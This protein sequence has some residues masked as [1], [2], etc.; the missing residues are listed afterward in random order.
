MF[1]VHKKYCT[2]LPP[3]RL[4]MLVHFLKVYPTTARGAAFW[5]LSEHVYAKRL[6]HVAYLLYNDMCEIHW[7]DRLLPPF[8]KGE[9][10]GITWA[11]DGTECPVHR[12]KDW[13]VQKLF[14]S[15][16]KGT[17]TMLYE[18]GV[19]LADGV[20]VWAPKEGLPGSFADITS[21]RHHG[22]QDRLRVGEYF[23][24]DKGY[25]GFPC[26]VTPFRRTGDYS[27][28]RRAFNRRLSSARIVVEH[29][30]GRI[31]H[32]TCLRTK[33]RHAYNLHCVAFHVCAQLTNVWLKKSHAR[34]R[35]GVLGL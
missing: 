32:F 2:H 34:L 7:D 12:D 6:W 20:I 16:K 33:W 15:G 11:L 4:L 27:S 22:V 35:C 1:I 26:A 19:R 29:V 24:T 13:L 9:F 23:L 18:I 30:L 31:K 8:P 28:S 5:N 21:A 14:Y 17:H 3:I 10:E 25:I